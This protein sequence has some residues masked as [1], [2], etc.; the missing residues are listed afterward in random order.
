MTGP[1]TVRLFWLGLVIVAMVA[2]LLRLVVPT[3][4]LSAFLNNTPVVAMFVP[5]VTGWARRCQFSVSLMLIPLSYASILGGTCTLVGTSTNLI[6]YGP[7]GY[8]F[9]DFTKVGVPLQVL[10]AIVCVLLIPLVWPFA[11]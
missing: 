1:L 6:V 11:G 2:V 3:A 5:L 7:G 10:L 8:R 4:V 9:T